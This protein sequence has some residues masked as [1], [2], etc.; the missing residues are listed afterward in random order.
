MIDI[1]LLYGYVYDPFF[2]SFYIARDETDLDKNSSKHQ[3]MTYQTII[4]IIMFLDIVFLSLITYVNDHSE[5][6]MNL[7]LIFLNYAKS[8]FVFDCLAT[9]PCLI[10]G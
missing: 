4:D 2:I 3:D 9:V 7:W 10:T 8:Q 1:C 6:E 5:W